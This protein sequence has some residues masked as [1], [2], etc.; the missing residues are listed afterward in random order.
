MQSPTRDTRFA[1]RARTVVRTCLWLSLLG[2]CDHGAREA[3]SVAPAV[4]GTASPS[5]QPEGAA[6]GG[7]FDVPSISATS[8]TR[9]VVDTTRAT[10]LGR[11]AFSVNGRIQPGGLPT[12]YWFEYGPTTA[13][14]QRTTA[15]SLPPRLAAYYHES[16]SGASGWK[17]GMS[18]EGLASV[19]SGGMSGGFVR[20]Q[21]PG[22]I[23]VNHADGIGPN[24]LVQ[25]MYP[26]VYE[27]G[28]VEYAAWSAGDA[29]LR[30]AKISMFVR[31]NSFVPR[32]SELVFW[33]QSTPLEATKYDAACPDDV[34]GCKETARWANWA[35]TGAD[36]T[37]ALL[38]GGWTKIE[39]RLYN[40]TTQWTYA[41][42]YVPANRADYVYVPLDQMLGRA[43]GD[44][45]HMLVLPSVV[46]EPDGSID[47]DDFEIVYRNRSVLL[48]SNGGHLVAAP[49]GSDDPAR[50]TD[51]WRNGSG[52]TW[53]SAPSPQAPLELTYRLDL[54]VT[55]DAVQI[56]Q[57]P[58]WP[59]KG[60]EVLVS[61]D[62]V[63]YAPLTQGELPATANAGANYAF[64][65]QRGLATTA[66]YVKVRI[67]S[68]YKPAYWGLGEIEVF[69]SG[70][71]MKT[72]DDW[73]NV[74]TDL[75]GVTAGASYHY[76]L[77]AESE[78]GM[79]YGG[80]RTFTVPA[81]TK[82]VVLTGAASR[83]KSAKAK[84]EGRVN[85][86]GL[87]TQFYF[88]YGLDPSYGMRTEER[89]GGLEIT[90]R[91]VADTIG[92]LEPGK[93]YHYRV[94]ATN[95]TGVSYGEDMSFL[96]K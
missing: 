73:Y 94:V 21:M 41:G 91:T 23:D 11:D 43:N 90:P 45:F 59:S 52:K 39:Y 92:A 87:A 34:V 7:A 71:V 27:A 25:Y 14:G 38:G 32:G 96:A 82:P 57:N 63:T 86:L 67:L 28:D 18:G 66:S 75:T 42:H 62:G 79:S 12:R 68:G 76:R 54:P 70:A 40:D 30:D 61:K 35:F 26:S 33:L 69:G 74:T 64:F 48:A 89:Y 56:H 51:G 37:S 16:W 15:A 60:V 78:L 85:P 83:I 93:T 3:E 50:L 58:D 44:I 2:G 77:V 17:G 46:E 31:G 95:A 81:T 53:R 80:D 24:E 47:M 10:S 19:A 6:D 4:G 1:L 72:D 8:N 55:I 36:L 5:S 84:V 22:E 65:L 29:D 20:Y 9:V 13:Y 88:E 49:A